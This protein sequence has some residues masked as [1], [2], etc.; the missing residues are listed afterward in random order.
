MGYD[1]TTGKITKPISIPDVAR[2]LGE[3]S[4]N[5]GKLC[6]SDK[7]NIWSR[8]KPVDVNVVR[9]LTDA[10]YINANFGINMTS[11]SGSVFHYGIQ[12]CYDA[13]IDVKS[14]WTLA[15]NYIKAGTQYPRYRISDFVGYNKYAKPPYSFSFP[16]NQSS[17]YYSIQVNVG[18]TMDRDAEITLAELTSPS[19]GQDLGD[20]YFGVAYKTDDGDLQYQVSNKKVSDLSNGETI[21][22][23]ITLASG[24]TFG[25]VVIGTNNST[26]GTG[27]FI[28]L[29]NGY[30][31][32]VYTVN[33]RY[34]EYELTYPL[35]TPSLIDDGDD[36]VAEY[37]ML[38]IL[39]PDGTNT[40]SGGD[41]NIISEVYGSNTYN[42]VTPSG[43]MIGRNTL[44]FGQLPNASQS[45]IVD[46]SGLNYIINGSETSDYEYL[47]LYTYLEIVTNSGIEKV[48][49]TSQDVDLYCFENPFYNK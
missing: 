13:A 39:F 36:I 38:Q 47:Q 2:C 20:F 27:G 11:G 16:Q 21:N 17:Y 34:V 37:D 32:V 18:V 30:F 3:M 49:L 28:F 24:T 26:D 14:Q 19:T 7:I 5:L 43:A 1:S 42:V 45:S 41:V 33:T 25:V 48:V 15:N 12:D 22:F 23:E 8:I 35:L 4:R 40:S 31:K 44:L 6:R 29:P 10:D 9:E 46:I